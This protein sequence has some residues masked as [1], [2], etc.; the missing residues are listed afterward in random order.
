MLFPA[1]ISAPW[2]PF[3]LSLQQGG[4]APDQL[5]EELLSTVSQ[6]DDVEEVSSL[7]CRGVSLES[8]RDYCPLKLA[9]TSDRPHI[10]SLM[11]ASG[12]SLSATLLL[13]AWY[14]PNVTSQVLATL[15]TVSIQ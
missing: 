7:L 13:E 9:V 8:R 14:S 2:L 11:L 1:I 4:A 5:C 3:S 10:A 15:T 6:G 12:A